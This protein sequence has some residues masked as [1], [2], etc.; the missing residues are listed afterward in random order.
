MNYRILHGKKTRGALRRSF[1]S[2][3]IAYVLAS[4]LS[5]TAATAAVGEEMTIANENGIDEAVQECMGDAVVEKN[6]WGTYAQVFGTAMKALSSPE[7]ER[8]LRAL[9]M[10]KPNPCSWPDPSALAALPGPSEPPT[11]TIEQRR[12]VHA[13]WDPADMP[14]RRK[15]VGLIG[16]G[17]TGKPPT[18]A[19]PSY[20]S[21]P[22]SIEAM[23]PKARA[24]VTQ[25]GGFSPYGIVKP[26]ETVLIVLSWFAE[27]EV[28]EAIARAFSERNIETIIVYENE[29][30]GIEKETIQKL[31]AAEG[32]SAGSGE[33]EAHILFNEAQTGLWPD[34]E[35]AKNWVKKHDPELYAAAWP[36]V[37]HK[38]P[39]V[40]KAAQ[41]DWPNVTPDRNITKALI[42]YL[43]NHPEIDR[44]FWRE[45][46]LFL[47]GAALQHHKDKFVAHNLYNDY[48]RLMSKAGEF[49]S[50]VWRMIETK[51]IESLAYSDRVE[52]SDPEG[53]AI[54][55][56]M[57]ERQAQNFAKGAYLQGHLLMT[58]NMAGG[59]TPQS[60]VNY[61]AWG[62]DY[63]EPMFVRKNG[64]LCSTNAHMGTHPL[65][66][67]EI[68]D[69]LVTNVE[70]GGLFGEVFRLALQYPGMKEFTWPYFKEPNWWRLAETSL[71]TNP[72]YFKHPLELLRGDNLSE[73]MPAGVIH[74]AY[75]AMALEGPE[76][77]G[78]GTTS[79]VTKAF[80]MKYNL[81][82]GHGMHQHTLLP[83]Y[84]VRIR[85]T[86]QW[87]TVI[88]NGRLAALDDPEV[89]ALAARYGD[90]D[91]VLS[92]DYVPPYPGINVPGNFMEDYAKDPGAYW[93]KWAKGIV[94]GS[95]P[96]METAPVSLGK[97][98]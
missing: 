69:G 84:Q 9:G 24:A 55:W 71:A 25:T 72:K 48:L 89:R 52:V 29:L 23:M 27:R 61:P 3:R 44:V 12:G 46:G 78:M 57:T 77:S 41:I 74:W 82:V 10:P 79:P 40:R 54:W 62:S 58:P 43:D 63:I 1:S 45:A 11:L 6:H 37:E 66:C 76:L 36:E 5:M 2:E 22:K 83:T 26:G 17:P 16:P 67:V 92:S 96:Y 4:T 30:V 70:G 88:N 32:W 13:N 98:E 49:P 85:D 15:T 97:T 19:Y 8:N 42:T 18:P 39:D 38:D 50:S 86:D 75:G 34:A 59:R 20:L 47:V 53:T 93:T 51:T 95:S 31:F 81:P 56:D 87:E 73:R 28:Y 35:R 94:E 65:L 7:L 68:K 64:I 91:E 80:G 14:Q 90:P 33:L 21:R 60:M